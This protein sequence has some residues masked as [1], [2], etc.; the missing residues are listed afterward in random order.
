MTRRLI[1]TDDEALEEAK[2]VLGART[3]KDTVNAGLREIL[4]VH[5]RRRQVDRFLAAD[6]LD[7]DGPALWDQAWRR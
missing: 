6:R 5:A 1:D 4:A 7:S 3:Y 2:A